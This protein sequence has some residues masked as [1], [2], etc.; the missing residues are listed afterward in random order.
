MIAERDILDM[1]ARLNSGKGMTDEEQRALILAWRRIRRRNLELLAE[2][3]RY[4]EPLV[5]SRRN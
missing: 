1:E 3:F 5:V 4:S 2:T